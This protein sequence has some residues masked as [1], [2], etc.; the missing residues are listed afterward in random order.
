M[1]AQH[2]AGLGLIVCKIIN[3]PTF[4]IELPTEFGTEIAF[5]WEALKASR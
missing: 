4:R 3:F 2:C 5:R 1:S